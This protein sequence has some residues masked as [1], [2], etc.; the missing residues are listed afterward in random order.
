MLENTSAKKIQ[1]SP[2]GKHKKLCIYF[3]AKLA[4]DLIKDFLEFY[5]LEAT[6]SVLTSEA[7]IASDRYE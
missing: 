2:E 5:H 3:L 7:N 1:E 6:L 4:L